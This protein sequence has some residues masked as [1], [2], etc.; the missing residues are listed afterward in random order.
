[1]ASTYPR[2]PALDDETRAFYASRVAGRGPNGPEELAAARAAVPAPTPSVPPAVE[3]VA[4]ALGREVP[5][6]I[7]LPGGVAP[8]SVLLD[9]HGG[10]FYLGSAAADDVRNQARAELFGAAVVSVDY[11]LAPEHPWP[12]APDDCETAARWL[13]EHAGER[14]GTSRVVVVGFSAGATLAMTTLLRL[15]A[16][17]LAPAGA[18]L[19][20]GTY[21]LSGTTAAGRLFAD[22][23]FLDAY[24]G[25]APDRTHPDLSPVFADLADLAGLPP[26]LMVVGEHDLLLADNRAMAGRL[27]AAGVDVDLRVYPGVPHGFV[28]HPTPMAAAALADIGAWLAARD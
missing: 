10:G 17:G 14:F 6:R 24:A 26:V 4:R 3:E 12:A 21:D 11:R 9:L 22:E 13:L 19:Q 23:W 8:R 15:R 1:M 2:L 27:A 5:V 16:A 28:G 25:D 20:A 7:H 18:V